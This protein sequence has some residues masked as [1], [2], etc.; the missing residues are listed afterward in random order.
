[1]RVETS[2]TLPLESSAKS[3]AATSPGSGEAANFQKLAE[4][5]LAEQRTW[6]ST[7]ESV[8][9]PQDWQNPVPFW[10]TVSELNPSDPELGQ[11]AHT[12]VEQ[13]MREAGVDPGKI[14]M[15][16][17]E[18]LAVCPG[19]RAWVNKSLVVEY[20]NGETTKFCAEETLRRPDVTL[21]TLLERLNEN[22]V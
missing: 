1:M 12:V 6:T 7:Q 10:N 20:P 11:A 22:M 13:A 9:A 4:F 3:P 8:A 2:S 18:E 21:C 5:L 15:K 16:Y 14:K 19:V 17:L